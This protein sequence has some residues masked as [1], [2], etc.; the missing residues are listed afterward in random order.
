MD[1]TRLFK[2]LKAL[3]DAIGTHKLPCT[4]R[5]SGFNGDAEGGRLGNKLYPIFQGA[6][7]NSNSPLPP[8]Y[9][10][11]QLKQVQQEQSEQEE[12]MRQHGLTEGIFV[13][14]KNWPKG[15]GMSVA[16]DFPK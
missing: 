9:T 4:Y 16:M 2:N 11:A 5:L 13:F 1:E 15:F 7:W 3:C 14:D 12:W 10:P 6:G 8:N